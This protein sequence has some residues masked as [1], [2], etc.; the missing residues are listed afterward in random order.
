MSFSLYFLLDALK[1]KLNVMLIFK[2]RV[3]YCCNY[4][5]W[6]CVYFQKYEFDLETDF[7]AFSV[8]HGT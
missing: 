1:K 2:P 8:I 5:T 4:I 7:P 3:V 6:K